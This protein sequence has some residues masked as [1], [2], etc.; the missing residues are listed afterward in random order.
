MEARGGTPRALVLQRVEE[1]SRRREPSWQRSPAIDVLL[2]Q[3]PGDPIANA[4][5][6]AVVGLAIL[7]FLIGTARALAN[8]AGLTN[9]EAFVLASLTTWVKAHLL[10]QI[11]PIILTLTFGE[12]IGT[13]TVG[14]VSLNLLT[15][16]GIFAA[17]TYAATTLG[18][19]V[20]SLNPKAPDVAPTPA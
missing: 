5:I 9:G 7:D 20:N 11:L 10:F 4:A 16:A 19:I 14:S 2:A 18:S 8:S 3:I 17:T 12:A 13:I 15:T 6:L 1:R